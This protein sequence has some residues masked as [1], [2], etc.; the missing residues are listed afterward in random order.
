L[1]IVGAL[2][3]VLV[4]MIGLVVDAG[5]AY[6]QRR[7]VQNAA[8]AAALAGAQMLVHQEDYLTGG[9][10]LRN[11]QVIA[12]AEEFAQRNGVDPAKLAIYYTDISGNVLANAKFDLGRQDIITEDTFG[13]TRAEGLQVE[14]DR[15]FPTYLVR[16]LGRN[17]MTASGEALGLLACGACTAGDGDGLFPIAFYVES[18]AADGGK[19]VIGKQYTV[20]EKDSHFPGT[21]SFGWLSWDQEGGHTSNTTL[22]DN[23]ADTSRSG[24]WTVGDDIPTG[25][26][27]MNSNGVLQELQYRVEDQTEMDPPRPAVVT[28]PIFDT[29]EGTGGNK[30]YNVVGFG[31][32]HIDCYHFSKNKTGGSCTFDKKDNSKWIA[33]TFEQWVESTGESGCTNF[34]VCTAKLRPPLEVKRTLVGNVIPWQ[35]RPATEQICE[36][37][38]QPVDV[39][40]V[41]DISGSMCAHWDGSEH[42]SKPCTDGERIQTAKDVVTEFNE[43]L[44]DDDPDAWGEFAYENQAG[45]STYP[46]IQSSDTYYTDCGIA[47]GSQCQPG[48]EADC[49]TQHDQVYFANKDVNL[50]TD[51]DQVNDTVNALQANGGTSMPRGLQ[52]GREMLSD[53]AYHDPDNLKVLILT[54]DG[55][56]NIKLNGEWTGYSGNYTRPPLIVS[57]GCN[58]SV[59]QAAIQQANA[60]KDEGVIIFT[61]GIHEN[62]DQDLLQAIASP[63][64][65]PDLPHFYQATTGVEFGQ[66]YDQIQDRLP[67]LC[68][69]ECVANENATTGSSA[70]VRLYDD[71]GSLV[72]TTTADSSGGFVITDLEPGTYEIRAEWTDPQYGLFYDLLTWALGGEPIS[73]GEQIEVEIPL[74]TG[75]TH[76]DVYLRSRELVDCD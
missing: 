53:P 45:L 8:D 9:T 21:G 11:W 72:A 20:F 34:G 26:G 64:T 46:T 10:F 31:R 70:V 68:T 15:P 36:G 71:S 16:L 69:E 60:A 32:F 13:G 2:L 62:I 75:T 17:N 63:D 35:V 4:L 5:N 41:L 1:I 25:P 59:Y 22:V 51:I 6:A 18:F 7:I 55:M 65:D 38:E 30:T 39:L 61:I 48:A 3:I 33:G 43:G 29:T 24:R 54:T 76:K 52:Y 57:S 44:Q 27:V 28:L 50:T 49:Y 73:D 66:I 37:G 56:A 23:M 19:P 58:D 40:H 14:A 67:T 74:G 47:L 42:R 12:A